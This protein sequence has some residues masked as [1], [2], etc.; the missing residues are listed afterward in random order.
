MIW[1]CNM[2]RS[3]EIL[4]LFV[5]LLQSSQHKAV[6]LKSLQLIPDLKV[7]G[8]EMLFSR[9]SDKDCMKT[10][11]KCLKENLNIIQS[12]Y[13]NYA[14]IAQRKNLE[15]NKNRLLLF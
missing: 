1:N 6:L 3:G 7:N 5:S 10:S 13:S 8:I 9:F 11:I 12:R 15:P 4:C 2:L 14:F